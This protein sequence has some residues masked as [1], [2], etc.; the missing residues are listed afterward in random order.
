[1]AQDAL[2]ARDAEIYFEAVIAAIL[3]ARVYSGGH[4]TV[5][6]MIAMHKQVLQKL[7]EA[8]AFNP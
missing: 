8:G 7:R 3:A 5:D 6:N 2:S 4:P 1:M